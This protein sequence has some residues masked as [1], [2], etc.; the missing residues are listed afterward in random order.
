MKQ[1]MTINCMAKRG[2]EVLR[3]PWLNRGAAFTEKER[4]EMGLR[5]LLPP[6]VSSLKD[7][8]KRLKEVIDTETSPI[9]KYLT[10]ESVHAFL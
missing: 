9:N 2:V 7:Q 1:I 4:E 10:L 8:A 6:A 3:N 5:G